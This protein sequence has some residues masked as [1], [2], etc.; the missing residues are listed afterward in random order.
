MSTIIDLVKETFGDYT[1]YLVVAGAFDG[2]Y[3]DPTFGLES[4]GWTTL[5]IEPNPE[6]FD[7]LVVN[8]SKAMCL[9]FALGTEPRD[10]V[11]FEVFPV[12]GGASFSSFKASDA[13]RGVFYYYDSPEKIINVNVRTLDYCVELAGF[14]D[15][16]VL[17]VDVEGWELE[18]L[19][20]FSLDIWK[21]KLLVIENICGE[22][23]LTNY[24]KSFGYGI[25]ERV[26]Y[27]DVFVR[28]DV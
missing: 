21:P 22:V 6:A 9:Q 10:N 17:T 19:K 16:D 25:I 15:V 23:E 2:V 27:N 7:K 1:G 24:I 4:F 12:G 28:K 18:V 8:R 11:P 13:I 3:D 5:C 26:A 14:K 20:S